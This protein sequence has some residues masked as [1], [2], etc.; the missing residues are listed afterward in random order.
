MSKRFTPKG[1]ARLDSMRRHARTDDTR[2]EDAAAIQRL[3]DA[4]TGKPSTKPEEWN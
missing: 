4:F 2:A 1:L 3:I